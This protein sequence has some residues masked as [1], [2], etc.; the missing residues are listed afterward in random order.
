MAS[1]KISALGELELDRL[2]DPDVF[3]VNDQDQT[4]QKITFETLKLGLDR[5]SHAFKGRVE[6]HDEVAFLGPV[7]GRDVYTK[8]ETL[9]EIELAL[10]PV[11]KDVE[12]LEEQQ[13]K[14]IDNIGTDASTYITGELQGSMLGA[15][16]K[17]IKQA[18]SSLGL[19]H[20]AHTVLIN[21]VQGK[22]DDNTDAIA[23][24]AGRNDTQDGRLDVIEAALGMPDDNAIGDN[25]TLIEANKDLID[26]LYQLQGVAE[27]T[28]VFNFAAS[29]DGGLG[30]DYSALE[31]LT[32]LN[33]GLVA[34]K[35]NIE[36]LQTEALAAGVKVQEN[37]NR[38]NAL[39]QGLADATNGFSG[40][41]D[42]LAADIF[43]FLNGL[44]PLA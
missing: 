34:N 37:R 1:I 5:D 10:E 33:T 6:F 31:A 30:G 40:T 16:P 9:N 21:Q 35:V 41:A 23:V 19:A 36:A 17:T 2:S 32:G 13:G 15:G 44:S 11:I 12:A 29:A 4:T 18:L 28:L 25:T 8:G 43:A 38:I 26:K 22:V 42:E 39:Q 24:E 20:D 27:G 14:I 7:S 3:I